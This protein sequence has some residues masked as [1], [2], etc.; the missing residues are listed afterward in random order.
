MSPE[1]LLNCR[2]LPSRLNAEE[3]AVLIGYCPHD[4]PILTRS[5]LIKPL[6][7]PAANTVKYFSSVELEK[8]LADEKWSARITTCLYRYWQERKGRAKPTE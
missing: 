2:R 6:G 5:G 4:I 1:A 8:K 3:V 7:S